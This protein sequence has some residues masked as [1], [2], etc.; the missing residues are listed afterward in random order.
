MELPGAQAAVVSG[1]ELVDSCAMKGLR[2][3]LEAPPDV[4]ALRATACLP[5]IPASQTGNRA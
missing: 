4:R 1:F 2:K 3:G 5:R